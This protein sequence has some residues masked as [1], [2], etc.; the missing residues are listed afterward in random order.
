M[1]KAEVAAEAA[2]R[3]QLTPLKQR[4]LL[5][6]AK[7]AGVSESDLHEAMDNR[8][9]QEPGLTNLIVRATSTSEQQALANLIAQ[10]R[11]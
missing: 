1:A 6:R 3:A 10:V 4:A 5:K 9:H 11:P 2:L 8:G 7:D